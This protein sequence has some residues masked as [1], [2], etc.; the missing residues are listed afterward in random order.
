MY[1]TLA[2]PRMMS[3]AEAQEVWDRYPEIKGRPILVLRLK[4]PEVFHGG[5]WGLDP[6]D[7]R[8]ISF[9]FQMDLLVKQAMK[10][11]DPVSMMELA[12]LLLSTGRVE[13]YWSAVTLAIDLILARNLSLAERIFT[14]VAKSPLS[15]E[16][17][18]VQMIGTS[19]MKAQLKRA[20][21]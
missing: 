7:I 17:N 1:K 14:E 15:N 10:L 19:F 21:L 3:D 9:A 13:H 6:D 18:G 20:S 16:L 2:T 11:K 12:K 4:G 5:C 8:A